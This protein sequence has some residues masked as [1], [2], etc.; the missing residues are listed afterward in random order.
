MMDNIGS[1][2]KAIRYTLKSSTQAK[3]L[4]IFHL[5]I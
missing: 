1:L 5:S 4:D 3:D 2:K